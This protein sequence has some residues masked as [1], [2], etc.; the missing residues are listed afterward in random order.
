[1]HIS[2]AAGSVASKSIVLTQ[3]FLLKMLKIQQWNYEK[4]L[5]QVLS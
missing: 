4:P 5:G 3:N 1:M 2:M